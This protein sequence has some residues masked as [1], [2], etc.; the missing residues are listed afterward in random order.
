VNKKRKISYP[1][2]IMTSDKALA[3]IEIAS[4]GVKS[5]GWAMG[6]EGKNCNSKQFLKNDTFDAQSRV[7]KLYTKTHEC[8]GWMRFERYYIW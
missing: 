4:N 2:D 5:R 7:R 8:R 3:S 1:A 6:G